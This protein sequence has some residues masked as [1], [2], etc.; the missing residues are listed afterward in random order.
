MKHLIIFI[1]ISFFSAVTGLAQSSDIVDITETIKSFAKAGDLSD[2]DKLSHYLDDHFTIVSNRLFGSDQVS[3]MDKNTY[4]E[5][6][7]IKEFGGDQ[8]E[9]SIEG[10]LLNGTSASAKVIYAGKKLTFTSIVILIKDNN[11]TWKLVNETPVVA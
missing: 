7:R 4:L 10:I 6:I 11:G 8:R 3:I 2:A 1:T 5:K 9:V